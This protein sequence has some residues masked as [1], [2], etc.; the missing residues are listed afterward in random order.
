EK[1]TVT[2][3]WLGVQ[4]QPVTAD[5]A[6]S[7][8]LKPAQGALVAEAQPDGPAANAGIRAGDVIGSVNGAAIKDPRE[9]SKT[10]GRGVPGTSVKLGLRRQDEEKT[11][12]VTLGKLPAKRQSSLPAQQHQQQET[13]GRGDS[14]H[15]PLG[16]KLAPASGIPGAGTRGVVITGIDP[17]GPAADK[18][19]E[20]GDV[21][22]EVSG[23]PVEAPADVENAVRSARDAGRRALLM[24]LKSGETMRFVAV[25]TG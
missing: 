17:T 7:L 19:F 14:S 8:G 12:T 25:P 18:G 21:I 24:R 13:T 2:R 11:V 15:E 1:G 6:D 5:I 9:L 4:I 16:L 23:K 20:P 22:L 10:I 3:G